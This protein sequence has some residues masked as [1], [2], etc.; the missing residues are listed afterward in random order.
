LTD[1]GRRRRR[2]VLLVVAVVLL[3]AV[4]SGTALSRGGDDQPTRDLTVEWG[5][6]EGDPCCVYDPD[7]RTVEA[8]VL[9]DGTGAEGDAVTV[10]VTAY[11]DENTS[12]PVGSSTRRVPVEG[13]VHRPVTLTIQ[14]DRAP[15]VDEDGVVACRLSVTH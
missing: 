1:G 15:H 3:V 12:E 5:G 2:R 4:G 11:A 8:T 10:T 9:V 14:V 13:A 6:G 7:A